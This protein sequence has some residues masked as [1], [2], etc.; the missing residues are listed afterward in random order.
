MINPCR[1]ECDTR[2]QSGAESLPLKLLITTGSIAG[3]FSN[4]IVIKVDP[5]PKFD[6]SDP[7][8]LEFQPDLP[9]EDDDDQ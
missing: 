7:L 6:F 3:P 8:E 5:E 4:I 1:S 2:S 9:F